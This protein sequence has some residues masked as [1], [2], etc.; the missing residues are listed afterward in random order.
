MAPGTYGA[1]IN[2]ST[3]NGSTTTISV[4]L[5][6]T[7]SISGCDEDCGTSGRAPGGLAAQAYVSDPMQSGALAAAWV[8]NLG[9][10]PHN[11]SDPRNQGLVISASPLAPT[12]SMAGVI[13][14]N[15][16]G[17]NLTGLGLDLNA[18]IQCGANAPQFVVVTADKVTH[19]V[20]GCTSSTGSTGSTASAAAAQTA[21]ATGWVHLWFD[22][23]KATPMIQPTDQVQSIS[24]VLGKGLNQ[25]APTSTQSTGSIAVID[26]IQINGMPVG[27]GTTPT[28]STTHGTSTTSRSRDD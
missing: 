28:T 27:K 9:S 14:Q 8:D 1:Q 3:P 18:G 26:N 24:V 10:S 4:G 7:P 20:G 2:V 22:P 6:I 23:Q 11:S 12:G 15:V 19:T 13:I 21:P 5:K 17:M 16:A 25:N